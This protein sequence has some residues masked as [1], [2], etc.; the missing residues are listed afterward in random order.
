ME[1]R[2]LGRTGLRVGVV[3]FGAWQLNNP[4]WG[5]PDQPE[6]IRLVQAALACG[7]NF[8]DTAPGYGEGASETA[9]GQALRGRRDAAVICTKF[10]HTDEPANDFT[11]AALRPALEGSLRRLQTEHVDLLLL[12]NPPAARLDGVQG[13]DLYGALAELQREGKVRWFGA[14]LDHAAELQILARTTPGQAAEILFNAFH[15]EP[16]AAL[17]EAHAA[18]LGVIAKVPFDSGWLSGKYDAGARF[19]G[20]RARWTPVQI[21]RRAS[22]V[23]RL[24]ALLPASVPLAQAALGCILA[25]R[26][27]ATVSPGA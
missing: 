8:F 2:L 19:T 11:V 7:C 26:E 14:S 6:S 21:A 18:G 27:M 22:L 4:Q 1:T 5:G 20:I 17:A 25:H 3:G 23:Q 12:H 24:R 10:G 9:L 16:A 13:A 15:Q